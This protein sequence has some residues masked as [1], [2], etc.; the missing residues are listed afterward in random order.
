MIHSTTL[1]SNIED[2]FII[3]LTNV[4]LPDYIICIQVNDE[5][6]FKK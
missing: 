4:E 1:K 2:D 3:D 5:I 6:I